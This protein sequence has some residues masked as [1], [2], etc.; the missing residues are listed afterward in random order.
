MSR[1]QYLKSGVVDGAEEDVEQHV[2]VVLSQ[3]L[4]DGSVL[5]F[6]LPADPERFTDLSSI[7][8]QL[9][10]SLC[11]PDGTLIHVKPEEQVEEDHVCL[12]GGGMHSLF[13]TCDVLFNDKH[14]SNMSYYPI[15]ATI[16]RYLGSASNVRQV[17]SNFD[18][19]FDYQL[20]KSD[21]TAGDA[22]AWMDD[23]RDTEYNKRECTGRI[24][25][26]VLMTTQ[27]LLPPGVDITINLRRAPDSFS[28]ISNEA[29]D[30]KARIETAA[31]LAK[32][33]KLRPS[34][35]SSMRK[36]FSSGVYLNYN[37]LEAYAISILK[38][39]QMQR[40]INCLNGAPLPD[41]IYLAF[42]SQDSVNGKLTSSSTYLEN[43]S[44]SSINCQLNG[45]DVLVDPIKC[46]VVKEADGSLDLSKTNMSQGYLTILNVFNQIADPTT[47]MRLT[48]DMYIK[49]VT[50]FCLELGKCGEKSGPTGSLDL[51]VSCIIQILPIP[52]RLFADKIQREHGS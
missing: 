37:R 47:P 14:V 45:R 3:G 10:V 16:I 4:N 6:R 38:S 46:K 19:T 2:K 13:K 29:G 23:Y 39:V 41:R 7:L 5:S 50:I 43:L 51:E 31:V 8:L 52:L 12:E 17:W 1:L 18:A 32:R 36:D 48:Y 42:L 15:S 26:D 40:W 34:L 24:Y 25:S 21:L 44:V 9:Q 49:G 33:L 22:P 30:Y 11:A 28:L 27:Q 20:K 35:V